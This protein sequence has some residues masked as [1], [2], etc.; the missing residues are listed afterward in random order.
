MS[1]SSLAVIRHPPR[2]HLWTEHS[3]RERILDCARGNA[4]RA[5]CRGVL[6]DIG[7]VAVRDGLGPHARRPVRRRHPGS[8]QHL[9]VEGAASC[10]P[11]CAGRWARLRSPGDSQFLAIAFTTATATAAAGPGS[12]SGVSG[13]VSG[14]QTGGE[15]HTPVGTSGNQVTVI[16]TATRQSGP[17]RRTHRPPIPPTR[18]CPVTTR[19]A[20]TAHPAPGPTARTAR[21]LLPASADW[22][23]PRSLSGPCRRPA[24][25]PGCRTGDS[26]GWPC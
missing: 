15:A 23:L 9:S 25:P 24:P 11:Q 19:R 14:N 13:L 12:T 21:R 1:Q 20:R 2:P 16:G 4:F 5:W 7:L 10:L 17:T 22:L 8:G 3:G 18:P 6:P 26:S